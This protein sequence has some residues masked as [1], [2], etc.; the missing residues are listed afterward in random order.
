MKHLWLI[1]F[2]VPLF[3]QNTGD[4]DSYN[5]PLRIGLRLGLGK[6]QYIDLNSTNSIVNSYYN[7]IYGVVFFD[8]LDK[9]LIAK[10]KKKVPKKLA[11]LVNENRIFSTTL[12]DFPENKYSLIYFF[13]PTTI[14]Y[15][16]NLNYELLMLNNRLAFIT[17]YTIEIDISLTTLMYNDK[18]IFEKPKWVTR[19]S[20][21]LAFTI[22]SFPP[23]WPINIGVY[24]GKRYLWPISFYDDKKFSQIKETM[25]YLNFSMPFEFSVSSDQLN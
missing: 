9:E 19:P 17:L 8:E 12:R 20:M 11:G 25:F 4:K 6:Q 1:L 15:S 16:N 14:G 10:I 5:V 21:G 24:Y 23:R 18:A 7:D 2:V 13:I 22:P 3:A